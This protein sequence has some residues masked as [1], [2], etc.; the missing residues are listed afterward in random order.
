MSV[1]TA[2]RPTVGPTQPVI[3]WTPSSGLKGP[4]RENDYS[5]LYNGEVTNAWSPSSIHLLGKIRMGEDKIKA[6]KLTYAEIQICNSMKRACSI[7]I[8]LLMDVKLSPLPYVVK[9]HSEM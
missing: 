6:Y 4:Q 2:P 8:Y 9:S 3:Q 5:L 1:F 7:A